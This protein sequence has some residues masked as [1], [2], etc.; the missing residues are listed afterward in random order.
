MVVTNINC[1]PFILVRA[2]GPQSR[3]KQFKVKWQVGVL[4]RIRNTRGHSQELPNGT[5]PQMY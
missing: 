1:L 4:G 2:G 3:T 5:L